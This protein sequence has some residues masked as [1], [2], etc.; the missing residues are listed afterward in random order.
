M[1]RKYNSPTFFISPSG[2]GVV[3]VRSPTILETEVKPVVQNA[4]ERKRDHTNK[5]KWI[6]HLSG[7][8]AYPKKY[9]QRQLVKKK[10][11][12][13]YH[14]SQLVGTFVMQHYKKLA[15]APYVA[16]D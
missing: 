10:Q 1:E 14:T 3:L 11:S 2:K 4:T 12:S 15:L 8:A 7:Q 9:L 16:C 13:L 6:S 5:K